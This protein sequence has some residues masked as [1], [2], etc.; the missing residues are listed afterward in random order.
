MLTYAC[1]Q[2]TCM[3]AYADVYWPARAGLV[4]AYLMSPYTLNGFKFD[5]RI[6]V[7][8]TSFNPLK[9]SSSKLLSSYPAQT[10]Y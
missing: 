10:S 7:V 2:V 4:Q 1:H 9:V 6:Y 3:L 8:A 5:M